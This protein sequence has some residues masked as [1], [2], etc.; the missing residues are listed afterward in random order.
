LTGT[1][2]PPSICHAISI[3]ESL[4]AAEQGVEDITLSYGQCGNIFQDVAAIKTLSELGE[5][6][7][8][9][10]GYKNVRLTTAF[11]QWMGAFPLDEV[12][13]YGVICLGAVVA[14]LSGATK[15]IT[16]SI[17]EA[18]GVPTKEAN[19]AGVRVTKQV[20]AM[21]RNQKL[22][23]VEEVKMESEMIEME[24]RAIL[25]KVMA[26]GNGDV[27]TGTVKAFRSGTI[28][29]PFAPSEYNAGKVM[30]VRDYEG[31]VRFLHP[32][33]LPFS[34][35]ILD[36]HEHRISRRAKAEGRTPAFQMVLD[37]IYSVSE[38]NRNM[39]WAHD[40]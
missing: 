15:V 39:C 40:H 2:V 13:A 9:E 18:F 6:Y 22:T 38:A 26:L 19:A 31:A 3:I 32:G 28:D 21:L 7:V 10:F 24:T 17:Q 25:D 23:K 27:A 1:L 11:H 37:D 12:L 20:L 16:K 5:E 33:N 36:F 8:K 29:V 30:T 14:A 4:L 34:K 35:Q